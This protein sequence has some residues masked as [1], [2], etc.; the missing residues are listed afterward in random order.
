MMM[1]LIL[2]ILRIILSG[3]LMLIIHMLI[4][5][6]FIEIKHLILVILFHMLNLLKCLNRKLKLHQLDHI[7]LPR[8]LIL[9]MF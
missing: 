9:L 2:F 7:Y 5:L 4:M 1:K 3:K 6:I 8:H